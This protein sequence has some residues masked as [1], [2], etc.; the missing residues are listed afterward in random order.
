MKKLLMLAAVAMLATVQSV[1]A[2]DVGVSVSVGEP[3]FYGRIDIG[4][5]PRPQ[6]VYPQPIIVQSAPVAIVAQPLYLHVPPGHRKKWNKHCHKYNA[7]GQQV[8]FVQDS[9]YN[10]VY[11]PAY[12][13]RHRG[14]HH[15]DRDDHH[16]EHH[17]D[18]DRKGKHGKRRHHDD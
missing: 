3:G 18:H 2:T 8:Y 16:H 10:D 11:V 12:H 7:C 15:R 14:D 9:W 13:Q 5:F 6:I 17:H 4:N 1:Y